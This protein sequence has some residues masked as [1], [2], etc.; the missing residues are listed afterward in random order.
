MYI[1]I[2]SISWGFHILFTRGFDGWTNTPLEPVYDYISS[3]CQELT[4]L[5]DGASP[6]AMKRLKEAMDAL[7]GG[8]KKE[9][10]KRRLNF[11]GP[12]GTRVS[13]MIP[14]QPGKRTH[15]KQRTH[16]NQSNWKS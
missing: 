13:V 11:E 16:K 6:S 9:L 8:R 14:K 15:K 5:Y 7:I 10:S 12:K 4:R 1:V 3:Q 2:S